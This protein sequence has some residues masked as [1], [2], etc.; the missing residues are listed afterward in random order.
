MEE[1]ESRH[2]HPRHPITP[3]QL[4]AVQ[5]RL[6]SSPRGSSNAE[7]DKK[8]GSE[9]RAV[10]AVVIDTSSAECNFLRVVAKGAPRLKTSPSLPEGIWKGLLLRPHDSET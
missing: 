3:V 2:P 5:K 10:F 9:T 1:T 7:P 8:L 4:K 6:M